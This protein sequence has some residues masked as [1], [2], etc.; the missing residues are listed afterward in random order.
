MDGY[1]F[2]LLKDMNSGKTKI[3]YFDC[4]F[5]VSGDMILGALFDLG[6]DFDGWLDEMKK[7]GLE[8]GPECE[9]REVRR[10]GIRGCSFRVNGCE[11]GGG[12]A[13]RLD[14]V[15]KIIGGCDL[16]EVI[17]A[18]TI[19]AFERL[20]ACEGEIHGKPTREIQFHELSGLDTIVDIAGTHVALEMLGVDAVHSS[21]VNVGTG[22]V[23]MRHGVL[24]V[25]AP[26]AAKLLEGAPVFSR[27][28]GEL[29]TPT[30]ALL[31]T[32]LAADFGPIPA[33]TLLRVGHGAG[34]SDFGHPNI[35]RAFVG[36][37]AGP[38]R[39]GLEEIMHIATNI[40]DMDPRVCGYVCERLLAAGAMDVYTEPIYMKKNRPG[41]ILNV[42]C[43]PGMLGDVAD[44]IMRETSTLGVRFQRVSRLC[45][46]RET[47]SVETA[48]GTVRVKLGR[49]NDELINV[50]PE[51]E[52]CAEIARENNIPLADVMETARR[53][54]AV[55][56]GGTKK[57]M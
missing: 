22:F 32:Q 38:V 37:A 54:A 8:E 46:E 17:K 43:A 5:G 53:A 27:F 45:A 9:T 55:K 57:G 20:A 10:H 41:F 23:E 49:L 3:I 28:E 24:P 21:P 44:Y 56:F 15:E 35:L 40:D 2:T 31:I 47:V 36:E 6:V 14:D 26:A 52:D 48:H 12:P 18:K 11:G 16:D 33:M 1:V 13:R 19:A 29:T 42:L 25:P 51:Y 50:N 34:A 30:G 39:A 4:S 7:L